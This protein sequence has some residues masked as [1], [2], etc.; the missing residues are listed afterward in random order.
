M[1]WDGGVELD[2][3][4]TRGEA[5]GGGKGA[6]SLVQAG[7]A[8]DEGDR[9]CPPSALTAVITSDTSVMAVFCRPGVSRDE[10]LGS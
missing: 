7:P 2:W 5:V 4:G 3:G 6:R 8:E 9:R 10:D 1:N